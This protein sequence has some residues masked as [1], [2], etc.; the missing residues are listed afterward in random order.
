MLMDEPLTGLDIQSQ[1][2]I[3]EI[4]EKLRQRGVTIMIATHD[5]DQA[6]GRF[7][8]VML[9]NRRLMGFGSPEQVFTPE[10]LRAAYGGHL[11]LVQTGNDL[12]VVA[13]TC[14]DEGEEVG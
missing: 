5:L 10:Q 3:L 2:I 7:D 14:C 12:L 1:E 9:L 4:M 13:D 6:A 11:R 8:R